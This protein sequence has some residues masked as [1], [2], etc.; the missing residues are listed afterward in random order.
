MILIG[1]AP[2]HPKPRGKITKEMQEDAAKEK[3]IKV[4]AI[5]L[6]QSTPSK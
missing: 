6:P 2:P 5:L 3:N 4:S 1:D